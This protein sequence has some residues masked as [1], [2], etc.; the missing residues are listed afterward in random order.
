M[1]RYTKTQKDA[2]DSQKDMAI[3]HLCRYGVGQGEDADAWVKL[4]IENKAKF[5]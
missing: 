1:E 5:S 2:K 3:H 4:F